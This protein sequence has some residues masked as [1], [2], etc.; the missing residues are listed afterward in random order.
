MPPAG[1][2]RAI[3]VSPGADHGLKQQLRDIGSAV[4]GFAERLL[5]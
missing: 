1:P 3:V 5:G 2:G 4:A